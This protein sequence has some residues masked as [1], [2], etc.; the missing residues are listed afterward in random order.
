MNRLSAKRL[1]STRLPDRYI[2]N[3]LTGY[4]MRTILSST[5]L[6]LAVLIA[7]AGLF[8]SRALSK[9]SERIMV[10][11]KIDAEC[12][13]I[14]NTAVQFAEDSPPPAVETLYEDVLV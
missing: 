7:L 2:V 13:Q 6:V 12:K 5:L 1:A 9:D 8:G 3:L 10:S 11:A 14:N 4:L